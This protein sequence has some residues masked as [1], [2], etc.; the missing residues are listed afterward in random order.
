MSAKLIKQKSEAAQMLQSWNPP[1]IVFTV[2]FMQKSHVHCI[3][4]NI[5]IALTAK[6]FM[7]LL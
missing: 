4:C 7:Q 3:N 1:K 5:E 2:K 6:H